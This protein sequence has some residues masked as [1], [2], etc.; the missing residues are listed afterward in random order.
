[1]RGE[2]W[3]SPSAVASGRLRA[4]R[5]CRSCSGQRLPRGG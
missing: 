4:R 3:P 2:R 1:L 5:R